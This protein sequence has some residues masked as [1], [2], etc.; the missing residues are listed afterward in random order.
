M[1]YIFK[2][3]KD[4]FT[5]LRKEVWWL[6]LV[7]L[8]NRA[9]TMV[10]P[11]LSLYL[12]ES[13]KYTLEDVGW[14]L[15]AFGLG[16][17]IG[18]W[19]GGKLTDKLGYYPVMFWSLMSSGL[20][21]VLIQFIESFWG[22]CVGIFSV[23]LVADSFR[24]A[25]FVAINSYCEPENRTRSVSLIRL[26]INLGFSF[27][28]AIGGLIIANISY[29][30]LFWIDG[31][32]CVLSALL[33]ISVLNKTDRKEEKER[34]EAKEQ[35]ISPYRDRVYMLFLFI[36]VLTGF[37]FLQY[38]STVPLYYRDRHHLSE[39]YVGWLMALNGMLIFIFEM[40]IVKY[41]ENPRFSIYSILFLGTMMFAGSFLVLNLMDWRGMLLLGM[42]LMSFA[43]IL[44]FPF[45]NSFAM[46]R[47]QG[48][49]LGG[50]MALFTMAFSVSHILGH[51]SGMQ[52]IDHIGFNA[53]WYIMTGCL[54]LAALLILVLKKLIKKEEVS[55][56]G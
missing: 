5:G 23:M 41:F 6:A 8:V 46:T 3:Y 43:E 13:L 7:T 45:L 37:A 47:G 55:E 29:A 2:L 10:V 26:A 42:V 27:G 15:T 51:N 4:S 33:F 11:F 48:S 30:G 20:L 49:N 24:P 22:F 34:S 19:L 18:S 38:F 9:G 53:T 25:L 31:V 56:Q 17:V 40:P 32:T 14:V 12:T 52:L 1:L 35:T 50:Y 44:N 21:F 54:V 28:P 39:E 16:S 36:V